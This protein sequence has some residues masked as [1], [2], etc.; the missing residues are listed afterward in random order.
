M[1]DQFEE[2]EVTKPENEKFPDA[3]DRKR[4]DHVAEEMAEKAS[5]T[6]QKYDR[7]HGVISK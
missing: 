2:T 6:E 7:D 5:R 4:I 3:T 1:A